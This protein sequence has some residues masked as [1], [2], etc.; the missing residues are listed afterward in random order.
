M[1]TKQTIAVIGDTGEL[2]ASFVKALSRGNY[3]LL[4]YA[5]GQEKLQPL[6]NEIKKRKLIC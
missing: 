3:R 4:L 6:V 5:R 2:H 1:I